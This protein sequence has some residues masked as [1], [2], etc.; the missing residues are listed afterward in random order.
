MQR[1]KVIIENVVVLAVECYEKGTGKEFSHAHHTEFVC[2]SR[3]LL[4]MEM[5]VC[6]GVI[7]AWCYRAD[8]IIKLAANVTL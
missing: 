4:E 6:L 1:K 8:T 2:L 7:K 3:T 5:G